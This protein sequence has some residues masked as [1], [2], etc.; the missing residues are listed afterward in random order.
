[1]LIFPIV[2][3]PSV[4]GDAAMSKGLVAVIIVALATF[5]LGIGSLVAQVP[6][7]TPGT[8]CIVSGQLWCWA[9]Q[10]GKVGDPCTCPVPGGLAKGRLG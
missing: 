2:R 4:A 3:P 7:H 8:V 5:A 6:P 9:N 10:P 1:M